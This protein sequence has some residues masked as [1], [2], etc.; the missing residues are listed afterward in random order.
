MKNYDITK[1]KLIIWDLD[2]TFWKG[3]L[4][5]GGVEFLPEMINFIEELTL[6]GI[7]NSICSKNDFESVKNEFIN[8]GFKRVWDL[9]IFPSINWLPKGERVKN[10]I[11]DMN[12]RAENVILIDD[13]IS[14]LNE[15][16]FYSP[17]IMTAHPDEIKKISEEL[18][19]VNDYDFEHT[20]LKQYKIL[21]EKS[22]ARGESSNE[23]FLRASGIKICIKHDCLENLERLKKLISRT[24]Q[25]NFTKFRDE[26]IEE[27]IKNN[28]SGYVIAEDKFG[29]YGICGFYVL[30][31]NKLIHF[32]FSCRI[33]NM[34]IEQ[35][36]YNFLGK[37]E[38][39]IQG[40]V[41]SNLEGN[42]DW[43]EIEI[44]RAHV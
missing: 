37:P 28:E 40:E 24:N 14:N 19:L 32:L 2:D 15:A 17:E 33:M 5:E 22:A 43:I 16:K 25:L 34:G 13:N 20:R 26:N 39:N 9:F 42:P 36:L 8:K 27:T 18:Y 44:G 10:I 23:E 38:L 31:G 3:T 12:L 1:T 29:S 30:G 6:K 11:N 35:F 41:A 21:E 7:M 4:S